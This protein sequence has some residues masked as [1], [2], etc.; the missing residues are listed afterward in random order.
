MMII[1]LSIYVPNVD[2]NR[3]L[4]VPL[5]LFPA[6]SKILYQMQAIIYRMDKQQDPTI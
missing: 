3:L 5:C 4:G 6:A 2:I 1:G